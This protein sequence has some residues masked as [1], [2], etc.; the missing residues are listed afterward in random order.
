MDKFGHI[1]ITGALKA[2]PATE[3]D[4]RFVYVEASNEAVDQQNEVILAKALKD[5]ADFFLRFGNLDIDHVTQ[6]GLKRGIPDYELFEIGRPVDVQ[7]GAKRTFV[8]GEIYRGNTPVADKANRFWDSITALDP[9]QRWY[10]SVGGEVIAKDHEADAKVGRKTVIKAVRWSNLGFSRTPVN[11]EVPL[12]STIPIGAF[13]KALTADGFDLSKAL[14]A[15]YGSDAASLEG[16]GALRT[17]SL[18]G[19]PMN[20]WAFRDRISADLSGKR[21]K[22]PGAKALV[23][24]AMS[25]YQLS[26]PVAA[27]WVERFMAD[28]SLSLQK[29]KVKS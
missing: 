12:V 8:K 13:A 23:A 21:V 29:R 25:Q 5:S 6:I 1:S 22:D 26:R 19:A 28:L 16:G 10:P 3:G 7:V 24:H 2:T 27:E 11:A 9:P 4:K 17:Q 18:E 14:E 20:Y 15:G